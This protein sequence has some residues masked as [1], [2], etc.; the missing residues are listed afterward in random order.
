MK[1][2]QCERVEG[3][4]CMRERESVWKEG[5]TERKDM[6]GIRVTQAGILEWFEFGSLVSSSH[7]EYYKCVY[8]QV[9]K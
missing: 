4:A 9:P 2:V 8:N 3:I 7:E 6:C 1:E 5:R